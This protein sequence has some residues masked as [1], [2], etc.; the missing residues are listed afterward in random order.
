MR[1]HL[2][3]VQHARQLPRRRHERAIDGREA[4]ELAQ[5]RAQGPRHARVER[6]GAGEHLGAAAVRRRE[7]RPA[8]G[9]QAPAQRGRIAGHGCEAVELVQDEVRM[10]GLPQRPRRA[11][12][13]RPLDPCALLETVGQSGALEL[14]RGAQPGQQVVGAAIGHGAAQQGDEAAAERGVTGRDRA[15]ER[16]GDAELPEDLGQQGG[17][18]G[19][20]AHDDRHVLG[21]EAALADQARD[22]RGDE[23]ELGA[24]AAA[25]EQQQRVARIGAPGRR[26][27]EQRALERV[28]RGALV[29]LGAG[30]QLD[31]L[32][33]EGHEL[34]EGV[35]AAGEGH[36][37][38]LVGQRDGDRRGG[39]D[40]ERLDR[41]AL[42]RL[43]V[44][45][46]VE[47]DRRRAPARRLEAQRVERRLV[48]Q[49]AVAAPDGAQGVAI[50][51]VEAR[52]LLRV[53]GA[54]RLA[55]APRPH[56]RPPASGLHALLLELGDEAQEGLDEPGRVGGGRERRQL[57]RGR[58][59][60]PPR[61]RAPGARAACPPP[62]PGARSRA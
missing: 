35:A 18:L 33:A 6:L 52:Q 53:G 58:S 1:A 49:D 24:L 59:R 30:R 10:V 57:A 13:R 20:L 2:E 42:Q 7:Q 51:R 44:V 25:L 11:R 39:V 22:V 50:G 54:P 32:G 9:G 45:E 17:V 43:E 23:L 8:L 16:E 61:A 36:A 62:A 15:L 60:R 47:E 12:A 4:L 55:L 38:G 26:R 19:R 28:Q 34:L 27:L 14:A 21:R 31:V 41:V 48:V 40:G 46:A 37:P 29:V 56:G 5:G 3:V